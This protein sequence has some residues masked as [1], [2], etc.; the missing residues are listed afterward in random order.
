MLILWRPKNKL[1]VAY[2]HMLMCWSLN[3]IYFVAEN[4]QKWN[5]DMFYIFSYFLLNINIFFYSFLWDFLVGRY[6]KLAQVYLLI[7]F[8]I[9]RY[10]IISSISWII[11]VKILLNSLNSPFWLPPKTRWSA[12][13]KSERILR[14]ILSQCQ[15]LFLLQVESRY[16]RQG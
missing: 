5:S 6:V 4:S 13:K 11:M 15:K 9:S 12:A 10:Y 2:L 14:K 8:S 7:Y 1:C 16:D 3:R